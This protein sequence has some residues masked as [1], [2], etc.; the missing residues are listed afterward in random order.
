MFQSDNTPE[1]SRAGTSAPLLT[2]PS[3]TDYL[4]NYPLWPNQAKDS[5]ALLS[6]PCSPSMDTTSAILPPP[7]TAPSI[8]RGRGRPRKKTRI[9]RQRKAQGKTTSRVQAPKPDTHMGSQDMYQLRRKRQPRYKCG[10]CG[11]RDC[12]CVLAVN[13][14]WDVPIGARELPP[15]RTTSRRACSSHYRASRKDFRWV[16]RTEKYPTET[17][18]QQV[19]VPGVA[20]APCP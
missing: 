9:P 11:L 15:G 12:A 7:P 19:A 16:E 8:K 1:L 20:K 13:E 17:I 18:L 2:Q 3:V 14:N 6:G 10:T 5:N 4:S